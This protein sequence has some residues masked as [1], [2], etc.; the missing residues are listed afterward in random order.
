[1]ISLF[2]L[3]LSR[4]TPNRMAVVANPTMK[5]KRTLVTIVSVDSSFGYNGS[6]SALTSGLDMLRVR[7][8]EKDSQLDPA[9]KN[10][11]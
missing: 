5:A 11:T 2:T 3:R 10:V 1:M 9:Q 6:Q 8:D 7:R 4:H